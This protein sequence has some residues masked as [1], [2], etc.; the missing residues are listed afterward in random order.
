MFTH[1]MPPVK[2]LTPDH[3]LDVVL[4]TESEFRAMESVGADTLLDGDRRD[5]AVGWVLS[6][7]VEFGALAVGHGDE[8]SP[9]ATFDVHGVR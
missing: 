6:S 2:L 1:D 5:R 7:G 4:A 3:G 9:I 8:P